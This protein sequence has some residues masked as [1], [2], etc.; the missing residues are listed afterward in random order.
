MGIQAEWVGAI[1][2]AV[3]A[4]GVAF[5]YFA[6]RDSHTQIKTA[7]E[8]LEATRTQAADDHERSRREGA[9]QYL[10]VWTNSLTRAGSSAAKL[11]DRVDLNT[12]RKIEA[13]QEAKIEKDHSELLTAC[14]PPDT[15]FQRVGEDIVLTVQQSA[16]IRALIVKYL[17]IL[18]SIMCAWSYSAVDEEIILSEFRFLVEPE[19]R[20]PTAQKLQTGQ[21]TEILSSD[22]QI[23]G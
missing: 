18:E 17:N 8:I 16:E 4:I 20:A 22:R 10:L 15:A 11:I 2:E 7:R 21:V 1:S 9:V 19:G 3:T 6:L 5:A 14:F 23:R 12:C 13:R